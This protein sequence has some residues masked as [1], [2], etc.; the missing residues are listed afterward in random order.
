MTIHNFDIICWSETFLD[1]T[2]QLDHL[3]LMM[4]YYT[5]TLV[6]EIRIYVFLQ[7]ILV[8]AIFGHFLLLLETKVKLIKLCIKFSSTAKLSAFFSKILKH[9]VNSQ[10][11]FG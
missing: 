3:D 9:S 2:F 1:L 4:S 7:A 8:L 6:S 5:L 10:W 11:S